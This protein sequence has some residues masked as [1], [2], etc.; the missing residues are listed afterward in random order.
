MSNRVLLTWPDKRCSPNARVH[1][2]VKHRANK[3]MRKAAWALTKDSGV[4]APSDGPINIHV[5]AFP[6]TRHARDIDNLLASMKGYFD[7]IA[8]ALKV[9][10]SRFRPTLTI[11]DQTGG[12][13]C[14]EVRP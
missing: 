13:L 6:P 8:D 5:T 11:S 12:Y 3:A 1:H 9:D 4:S 14:V 2:M 10:D 7:G